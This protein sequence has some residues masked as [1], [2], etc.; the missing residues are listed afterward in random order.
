MPWE[1]ERWNVSRHD[2]Q[3]CISV[4]AMASQLLLFPKRHLLAPHIEELHLSS[5]TSSSFTLRS[6]AYFEETIS[7]PMNTSAGTLYFPT[8]CLTTQTDRSMDE[9]A[10]HGIMREAAS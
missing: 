6:F 8:Q 5:F 7:N 1:G 4:A 2:L 3:D 10:R 9:L